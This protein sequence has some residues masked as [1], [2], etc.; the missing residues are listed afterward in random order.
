MNVAIV[1]YEDTFVRRLILRALD[2]VSTQGGKHSIVVITDDKDG[3]I[4]LK[5]QNLLLQW[6]DYEYIDFDLIIDPK[7]SHSTLV[8]S[9]I[10]RKALIRKNHLALTVEHHVA[11]HPHS[12][13]SSAFPQTWAFELSYSDEL[14][15]LFHD[16][17]YQVSQMLEKNQDEDQAYWF[18]LKPAM[19]DRGTGVHLF[20]SVKGLTDILERMDHDDDE[21]RPDE[22]REQTTEDHDRQMT[23]SSS[24]LRHFVI[25]KYLSRPLLLHPW[26]QKDDD[27]LY[28][29]HIR[30]Y[31][32]AVGGLKVYL[33]DDMLALFATTPYNPPVSEELLLQSA[34]ERS[35]HLTNTCLQSAENSEAF[36]RNRAVLPFWQLC[37]EHHPGSTT[38]LS[39]SDLVKLHSQVVEITGAVFEAA[40]RTQSMSFQVLPNVFEL[41]GVDFL[42]EDTHLVHLLEVNAY[43]DFR[44]TGSEHGDIVERLFEA[45]ARLVVAPFFFGESQDGENDQIAPTSGFTQCLKLEV[46]RW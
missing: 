5:A 46:R 33:W 32:L 18:I 2:K 1:R 9:Y 3:D 35:R 38:A 45:T 42:V 20:K 23:L 36:D 22:E 37:G 6:C 31:V 19:T 14:E 34:M 17:L 10:Y 4:D 44:Q 7:R 11:K 25:Q 43:P 21:D 29:F 40:V 26:A 24:S 39:H 28:K 27:C 8:N 15:E 12:I 13:L 16:E 41:F 30:A